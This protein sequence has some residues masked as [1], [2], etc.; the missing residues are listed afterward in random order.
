MKFWG[1]KSRFFKTGGGEEYQVAGKFIHLC[2][3]ENG[4]YGEVGYENPYTTEFTE[5]YP[6]HN[7]AFQVGYHTR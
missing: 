5:E 4:Q 2:F 3:Q 1:S 7:G 6:Q